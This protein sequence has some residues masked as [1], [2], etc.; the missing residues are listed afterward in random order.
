MKAASRV[1]ASGHA[2][3][4]FDMWDA[5]GIR[6][7]HLLSVYCGKCGVCWGTPAMMSP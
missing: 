1:W 3:C 6:P 5:A 7:W 2:G 4:N